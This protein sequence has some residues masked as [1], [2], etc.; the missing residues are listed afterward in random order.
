MY[1]VEGLMKDG[2]DTPNGYLGHTGSV[3]VV[4]HNVVTSG[5]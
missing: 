5:M 4:T 3:T 2:V 1:N